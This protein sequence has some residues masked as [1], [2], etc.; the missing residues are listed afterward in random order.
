MG[1]LR[2]RPGMPYA[3]MLRPDK[4]DSYLAFNS[5]SF[6]P[7]P[8]HV[9]VDI[10]TIDRTGRDTGFIPIPTASKDPRQGDEGKRESA[11]MLTPINPLG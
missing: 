7:R 8:F 10:V 3:K 4:H 5:C 9:H 1:F 6:C 11:N 2:L